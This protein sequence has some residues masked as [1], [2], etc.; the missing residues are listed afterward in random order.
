MNYDKEIAI[1]NLEARLLAQ[2]GSLLNCE[3]EILK[4]QQQIE[5]YDETMVSLKKEIKLT[6]DMIT[7]QKGGDK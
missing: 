2:Q 5:K 3:A 6:E 1:K 7:K 4:F